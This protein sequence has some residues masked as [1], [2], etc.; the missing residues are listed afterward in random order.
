MSQLL[1]VIEW[2]DAA[3]GE[4]VHRVPEVGSAETKLGSQLVVRD[5]QAAVFFRSGRGLDVFG[6]GR[7]TLRTANLPVLTKVLS[8]P[9]GFASPFR[10]EVYFVATRLFTNL[11]WGTKD[12]VAFRDR[13][14]GLVRLRAF[15]AFALRVAQPLLFVNQVVGGTQA[16]FGSEDVEGYLR[17]VIVS[18]LNDTLGESL[19]TL[20]D[21]PKHYDELAAAV[22]TRVHDDFAKLGLELADFFVSRITPPEDVQRALDERTGMT[23]VGDVDAYLK[24]KAAQALDGAARNSAG[25]GGVALGAGVG[26]GMML[27]GMLMGTRSEQLPAGTCVRPGV[28]ACPAC[29]GDVGLESRFCSH[30]G[31]QM[32]VIRKCPRCARNLSADARFCSGCGLEAATVRQSC[33][34]C[35]ASLLVGTKFCTQCG[36]KAASDEPGAQ[37][38]TGG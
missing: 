4:I 26:V 31:H 11:Q 27:P 33:A 24:F 19:D 16:T 25:A 7:H 36:E 23:A 15:G 22:K 38:P 20:L 34:H 10:C 17:E 13:E 28:V 2:V 21:L 5:G 37:P 9:W 14:L 3:G 8:L 29:H 32:V 1:E 12:P 30:C 35:G 6:P 18:R